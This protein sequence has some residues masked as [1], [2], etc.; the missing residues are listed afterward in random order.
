MDFKDELNSRLLTIRD[1]LNENKIGS[2]PDKTE[3]V[4]WEIFR[5]V[6]KHSIENDILMIREKLKQTPHA[7][8]S[9][10]LWE[11]L[12]Q[13]FE[14]NHTYVAFF[15][16]IS[17]LTPSGLS[18]SPNAAAGKYELLYRLLRPNSR[19]PK[20]GDIEE[21]GEIYEIK[22]SEVRISDPS[23]TGKTYNKNCKKIFEGKISGNKVKKGGLKD[24][25]V[26]EIEKE[27]YK[28]H[29]ETEFAK[30]IIESKNLL[31]KYFEKNGWEITD[32]EIN[33]I[34]EDGV[35]KQE[36]MKKIILRKMFIKYKTNT[37][38]KK[39]YIFG[40][41]TNVKIISEPED[42]ENI[43]ITADYFR[44]NQDAPVGWY[45]A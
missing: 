43:Q 20:K 12:L 4:V 21:N 18:T 38:F 42:L 45:I 29:Y 10:N 24:E 6:I 26:Y 8:S 39:M 35:W 9:G 40:D 5:Y 28:E 15:K 17:E 23:L 22:G 32:N 27:Q 44:I 1:W 37:N 11:Y 30:N 19:Q 16:N 14:G 36:I 3:N 13:Y 2:N 7:I 33:S 34:F 25:T 41:G 31:Q